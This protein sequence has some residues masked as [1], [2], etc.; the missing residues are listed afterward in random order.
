ME[1]DVLGYQTKF[2]FDHLPKT[3]GTAWR[4]VLEEIFGRENVTQ[5]LEGRSEVWAMQ[6]YAD[7]RVISGHFLS[8]L[9]TDGQNGARVHHTL[10]RH[11]VDRAIS[12]YFYW[13]HH[14]HEGVRDRLG[15]W[16]QRF[17][18][19]DFFRARLD[20]N[21]TAATN[22]CT[23]HFASRIT[24]DIDNSDTLLPIALESLR[25][26]EFV[27]IYE[28][29]HD[30][31]DM[32]CWQFALPGV[33]QVPR[34]N[35]TASR[36][37]VRDLDP[38]A[39]R[40]LTE[41]NNLDVQLYEHALAT[42]E[43]KKR[44]MFREL[45]RKRSSERRIRFASAISGVKKLVPPPLRR[46]RKILQT[47]AK[48][49]DRENSSATQNPHAPNECRASRRFE[50]FGGKEIEVVSVCA[51]GADSGTNTVSPGETVAVR[52]AIS[53]HINV[54]N[55][56]VGIELSDGFGEVVYGTN[57]F[58]RGAGATVTAGRDYDVVFTFR[59]NLNRGRYRIGVALHTGPDHTERC[60]HWCDNVTELE[61]AQLGEPDFI[62][63]CRLEPSIEWF[64]TTHSPFFSGRSVQ[65]SGKPAM[66]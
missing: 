8:L 59:A 9:P 40:I 25:R 38:S 55:L 56:T 65:A 31:V 61:I 4:T 14:A 32:F 43:S 35:V 21:E 33:R 53:A 28:V 41:M 13:R 19:C 48:Q 60:F 45:L 39:L 6:R 10:L 37:S 7:Y 63:Y 66:V 2:L 3:G 49:P 5:H 51:I 44:R 54:E 34:V 26:Y 50:S 47:N 58:I 57:T 36:V 15:D 24:R 27:G 20:S 16:A 12:E 42:F 22:F 29:L 64:E 11:P 52:I 1:L 46:Y 30:S 23:K 62:G 17:D 18:I